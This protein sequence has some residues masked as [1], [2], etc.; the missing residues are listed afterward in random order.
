MPTRQTVW[1]QQKRIELLVA[2]GRSCVWCGATENLTFDCIRPTGGRHHKLSSVARMTFY[3][4]E[5]RKGNVQVLCFD[6][7]VKK[8][9]HPQARYVPVNFVSP[10]SRGRAPG[11]GFDATGR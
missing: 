2:L 6:C 5:A 3:W 8:S 7:N 10:L 9:D 1:A 4:R 11:P